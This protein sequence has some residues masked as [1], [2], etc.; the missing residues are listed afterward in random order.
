MKSENEMALKRCEPFVKAIKLIHLS[1]Y[2]T[3]KHN[4]VVSVCKSKATVSHQPIRT[5]PGSLESSFRMTE[6]VR[7]H[8]VP[9]NSQNWASYAAVGI[10]APY[11]AD[12]ISVSGRL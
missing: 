5:G 4:T 9:N 6:R 12:T 10:A 11:F 1:S 2:T 3:Y 8:V 7:K